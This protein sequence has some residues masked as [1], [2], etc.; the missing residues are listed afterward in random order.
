MEDYPAEDEGIPGHNPGSANIEQASNSTVLT[1]LRLGPMP[2][3][4][5]LREDLQADLEEKDIKE[6]PEDGKVSLMEHFEQQIKQEEAEDA[7]TRQDIPLPPSTAR[8]VAMEVQKVKENRD[9]YKIHLE[10][11]TGGMPVPV[12]VVMYT[13][14]NTYDS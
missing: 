5:D 9:R 10:G 1:K 3:E 14:H 2:L 4:S 7:P 13:F 6:P 8:D 12:S 11:R